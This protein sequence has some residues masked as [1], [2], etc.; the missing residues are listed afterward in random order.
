MIITTTNPE[1]NEWTRDLG[2]WVHSVPAQDASSD[3]YVAS[4]HHKVSRLDPTT[5]EVRWEVDTGDRFF[6]A[7]RPLQSGGLLVHSTWLGEGESGRKEEAIVLDRQTGSEVW[8]TRLEGYSHVAE[9]PD[10]TLFVRTQ[11]HSLTALDPAT[12]QARWSRPAAQPQGT[13]PFLDKAGR[14]YVVE[15]QQDEVSRL[16]RLDTATGQEQWSYVGGNLG[17]GMNLG[18]GG[19][20]GLQSR[21][22]DEGW[23]VIANVFH[24][25]DPE[26]GRELWRVDFGPE[27][28]YQPTFLSSGRTVIAER[29]S[30]D[31]LHHDLSAYDSKTGTPLWKVS[32]APLSG[33]TEGPSGELYCRTFKMDPEQGLY[34]FCVQKRDPAT[35]ASLWSFEPP[36]TNIYACHATE[37]GVFVVG[38]R[39]DPDSGT[40][41][42]V[43]FSVDPETGRSVWEYA[44]GQLINDVEFAPDG[45]RVFLKVGLCKVVALDPSTGQPEWNY[46]TARE[47]QMQVGT[48]GRLL[49]ADLDGRLTSLMPQSGLAEPGPGSCPG[50]SVDAV[51]SVY[52]VT[53]AVRDGAR[54]EILGE[55]RDVLWVSW[56]A[57][58]PMQPWDG[59]LVQDLDR[60]GAITDKD[61]VSLPDRA[62]LQALDADKNGLVD[63]RELASAGLFRWY[64]DG[65]GRVDAN[66]GLGALVAPENQCVIDLERW[67]LDTRNASDCS[68]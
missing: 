54:K 25:V 14:L 53:Q 39:L 67:A 65:N 6:D 27:A 19:E 3:V 40:E 11:D 55:S 44:P 22:H 35:G 4:V 59:V 68:C 43:L 57:T 52:C 58:S 36:V 29:A 32:S 21:K 64:D 8:R 26:T 7:P 30:W 56:D 63:S 18:P 46:R 66:D 17:G 2:R 47:V 15:Q 5:G 34:G 23:Q 20:L 45:S 48:D 41:T 38:G 33:V 13:P 24:V 37:H 50:Q 49:L 42:Q 9:G 51:S 60:D 1:P 28:A 31:A 12:G 62:A 10:G 16:V 61:L